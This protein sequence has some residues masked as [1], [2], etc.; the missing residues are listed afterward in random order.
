MTEHLKR[1]YATLLRAYP[2]AYRARRGDELLGT[3][4]DGAHPQQRWPS[5]REAAS[6]VL[7]GLRTRNG[8]D[9][10]PTPR[11]MWAYALHLAVLAMLLYRS[12]DDVLWAMGQHLR[13]EGA[14]AALTLLAVPLLLHGRFLLALA[15]VLAALAGRL[16]FGVEAQ[17]MRGAVAY[18]GVAQALSD[19]L[20]Y[21]VGWQCLCAAGGLVVLATAL[22]PA[23][24]R[25]SPWW[26][27]ALTPVVA[28]LVTSTY[29]VFH[30]APAPTRDVVLSAVI[31]VG[32]PLVCLLWTP[33]DP[34]AAGAA[35]GWLAVDAAR[36]LVLTH[37]YTHPLHEFF[38]VSEN[39]LDYIRDRLTFLTVPLALLV[40][41]L[42]TRRATRKL[43]QL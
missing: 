42:G 21:G 32:V 36:L 11:Q 24:R 4:L 18:S 30:A 37:M 12:A 16:W 22:R 41:L 10:R 8:A 19:W 6:L 7:A 17:N 3:L 15:P 31:T 39:R 40:A 38:F 13:T 23:R 29:L 43:A 5:A 26:L 33:V 27:V 28:L 20:Q 9:T 2:R 25:L 34:R 1:R 14:S 35:A